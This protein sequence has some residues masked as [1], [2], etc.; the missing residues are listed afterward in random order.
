[1]TSCKCHPVV[2]MVAD[3][4]PKRRD[5]V[6]GC[7]G[8]YKGFDSLGPAFDCCNIC[9]FIG[10]LDGLCVCACAFCFMVFV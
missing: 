5:R 2:S 9:Q 10:Y 6:G 4:S 7:S 3:I 1:M 8:R